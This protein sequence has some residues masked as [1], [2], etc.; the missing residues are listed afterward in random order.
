M[1]VLVIGYG[2]IG[3]RHRDVLTKLGH[4]VGVVTRRETPCE[5]I[6][7]TIADG[8]AD[9]SPGY[10]VIASATNE[11][12]KD[13]KQLDDCGYKGVVLIE[14]PLFASK[15]DVLET[16]LS[17]KFVGYNLRFHP[18]VRQLQNRLSGLDAITVQVYAGQHLPDWRPHRNYRESYSAKKSNWAKS[19]Y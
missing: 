8:V 9:W 12:L 14:K 13:I 19:S 15:L 10:V 5:E 18:V 16:S 1:R 3:Q 6:F 7:E 11:H 2:S 17:D 4:E